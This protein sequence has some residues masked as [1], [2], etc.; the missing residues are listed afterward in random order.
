MQEDKET[1]R[2][3]IANILSSLAFVAD[4]Q[5]QRDVWGNPESPSWKSFGETMASIFDDANAAELLEWPAAALGMETMTAESFK[6][7]IRGLDAFSLA[8]FP[9]DTRYED[10]KDNAEWTRL[11]AHAWDVLAALR[12]DGCSKN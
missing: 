6:E 7:L 1:N 8:H 10:L 2:R 11:S 4:L 5:Y 9:G 3:R 12:K